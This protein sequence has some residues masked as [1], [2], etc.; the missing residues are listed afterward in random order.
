M[1]RAIHWDLAGKCGFERNER[2]YDH[3]PEIVL[4]ENENYKLLW[5][6]S[7]LTDHEIGARRLELVIIIKRDKS[8][9]I[10]EVVKSQRMDRG[11]R[12]GR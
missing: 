11:E 2:R 5:D 9:Q 1:A 7:I 10:M 8:C 12:K 4:S 6:F 3:V